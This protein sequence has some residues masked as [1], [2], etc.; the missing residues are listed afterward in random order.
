MQSNTSNRLPFLRN[1]PLRTIIFHRVTAGEDGRT[2]IWDM[3]KFCVLRA[4]REAAYEGTGVK[5]G[6][7][8]YHI[9]GSFSD[10]GMLSIEAFR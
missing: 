5:A 9:D 6:A 3:E 2:I 8:V 1:V 10:D 4:F 7:Y